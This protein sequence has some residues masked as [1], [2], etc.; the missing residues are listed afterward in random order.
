MMDL[1]LKQMMSWHNG[2]HIK[3]MMALEMELC[4]LLLERLDTRVLGPLKKQNEEE[5]SL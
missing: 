1:M 2:A 3:M 5:E 4:G